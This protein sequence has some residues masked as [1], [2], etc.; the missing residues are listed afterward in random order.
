M[1]DYLKEKPNQLIIIGGGTSIREGVEKG[2]W[3]KIKNKFTIGCNYSFNFHTATIQCYLDTK[4]FDKQK[5]KLKTLP[6]IAT[7]PHLKNRKLDNQIM[8]KLDNKYDRTLKNG[9]YKGSL[10]GIFALSL[11][12]YLL[13]IGEIF[14]LGYDF[15]AQ[16]KVD[17]P[18]PKSPKFQTH[19]YQGQIQHSGVGKTNYY[20]DKKAERDFAPFKQEKKIKIYNVSLNSK[21]I[22]F[23]KISYDEF[24]KKLDNK[25]Y[26]HSYLTA[27]T[28]IQLSKVV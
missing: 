26:C 9:V 12:I 20:T 19:F 17:N 4:F 25:N 18:K 5:E 11:A 16:K 28:K 8:L 14:I 27:Y 10:T 15:G 22:A 3:D 7:R 23:E 1:S 6:F 2:L 21:I 24:F 13:D